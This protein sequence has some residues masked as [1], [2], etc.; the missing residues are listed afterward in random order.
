[1]HW[2]VLAWGRW[3]SA[4][5]VEL[6]CQFEATVW[7][8]WRVWFVGDKVWWGGGGGEKGVVANTRV[9]HQV[10]SVRVILAQSLPYVTPRLTIVRLFLSP[11]TCVASAYV[12]NRPRLHSSYVVVADIH[13]CIWRCDRPRDT[14]RYHWG[15]HLVTSTLTRNPDLVGHRAPLITQTQ[16]LPQIFSPKFIQKILISK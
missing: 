7:L 16:F 2:S 13:R 9:L 4:S 6:Q 1:M 10:P 11:Y 8:G 12:C 14:P 5:D 3:S 15:F